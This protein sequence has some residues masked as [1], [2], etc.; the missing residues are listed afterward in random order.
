MNIEKFF[1][2]RQR[3]ISWC[4]VL[5]LIG[6]IISM[7]IF[8]GKKDWL[9]PSGAK[10]EPEIIFSQIPEKIKL[11]ES[12]PV[13]M[14]IINRGGDS[15]KEA[16]TFSGLHIEVENAKV[17]NIRAVSSSTGSRVVIKPTAQRGDIYWFETAY[18][19]LAKDQWG[20]VLFDLIPNN[21]EEETVNIWYRGW[22]PSSCSLSQRWTTAND[23]VGKYNTF[24]QGW[25]NENCIVRRPS[26][27]SQE[28]D[29]Q[30]EVYAAHAELQIFHCF[31]KVINK[32]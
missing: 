7:A 5:F 26:N 15:L 6:L 24:A 14:Q 1:E 2:E 12:Y 13:T 17:K 9:A 32:E 19:F 11:G 25:R 8:F 27:D 20:M 30:V 22:S 18:D 29:C 31:K 28:E 16:A 10:P 3:C 21:P 4:L 23:L